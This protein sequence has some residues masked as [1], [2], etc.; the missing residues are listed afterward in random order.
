[1]TKR[2][3]LTTKTRM[4]GRSMGDERLKGRLKTGTSAQWRCEEEELR[5][6]VVEHK[7]LING[8]GL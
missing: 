3:D 8:S 6:I 5:G 1:M 7:G 2:A 4:T